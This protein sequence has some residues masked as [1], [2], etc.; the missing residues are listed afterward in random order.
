MSRSDRNTKNLSKV[1]S[2]AYLCER[3]DCLFSMISLR[4]TPLN[5]QCASDSQTAF[6]VYSCLLDRGRVI[7][8]MDVV[9][10]FRAPVHR[11]RLPYKMRTTRICLDPL[12]IRARVSANLHT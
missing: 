5:S 1:L 3:M 8:R 11:R 7:P 4:S 10:F 6:I 9:V 2:D 12:D